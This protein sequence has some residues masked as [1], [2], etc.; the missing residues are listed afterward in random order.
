MGDIEQRQRDAVV[1][2]V[3]RHR[4]CAGCRLGRLRAR[5][6]FELTS[7][8]RLTHSSRMRFFPPW[9][10]AA[11]PR[12]RPAGCPSHLLLE[13]GEGRLVGA[14]P[15]YLKSHSYGEYV[16]DHGWADAYDA[17]RRQLLSEAASRRALHAGD[18][19]AP[20]RARGSR[21]SRARGHPVAGRRPRSPSTRVPRRCTSPSSP[22]TSGSSP[23]SSASCS[24][25]TSNSTGGTRAMASFEDFLA[26]LS[27]R[28]RKAIRKERREALERRHRDRMGDGRAI[29]PRPIGTPSSPSTWTRARANGA[30]PY[31][32]REFFSLIG[33]SMADQIL[34]VL[35][36]RDGPLHRRRA[37]L[38]RRRHALWPLLGRD[39]GAPLPAFRGL[40]L[41]GHRLRHRAQA[42]PRRGRRA[43]RAQARPR[44]SAGARP[45]AP[46]R[47]RI[48]AS[49][50]R[51]PT[52]SSASARRCPGDGAARRGV[53]YRANSGPCRQLRPT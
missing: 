32:T 37:Q 46:I 18:R 1:V 20:A 28:K 29:S 47:S 3:A 31:L 39:R 27:S 19:Q 26:A 41:P 17:R 5:Q 23:A 8:R 53:A 30:S 11:R 38:H 15:C 25:P 48:R 12:G 44:L 13:D 6:R 35:A 22:S 16:F 52:I 14:M 10:R 51:S 2:R 24:A 45:I 36:K 50:A 7:S 21:P 34:L 4:R 49:G 33:E 40:L 43:R 42:R 9:R